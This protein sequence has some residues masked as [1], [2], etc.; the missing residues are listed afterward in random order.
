MAKPTKTFVI[1]CGTPRMSWCNSCLTSARYEVDVYI[2]DS[3]GPLRLGTAH[4]CERC[5]HDATGTGEPP[6]KQE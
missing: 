5:G 4:G 2:L 1:Q 3:D 6:G